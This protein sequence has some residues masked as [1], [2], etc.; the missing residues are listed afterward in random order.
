MM[1]Q[2]VFFSFQM[3]YSHHKSNQNK[4]DEIIIFVIAFYLKNIIRNI[5]YSL[6]FS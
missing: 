1:I 4:I 6:I 3:K 2:D 5:V